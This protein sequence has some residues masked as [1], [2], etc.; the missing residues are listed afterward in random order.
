MVDFEK[1]IFLPLDMPRSP[2]ISKEL[3]EIYEKGIDNKNFVEDEY[4]VS[5]SIIL[6][7]PEGE[8]LPIAKKIPDFVEWTED[9]LFPWSQ[10]SQ[11]VVITTKPNHSMAPH[12]DCA[13][14][15]FA[16]N[17]QH[18]FRHVIRG[19][20]NSLRY[21][22]KD[23]NEFVP[24]T[25][26]PY[27]IS[28]RWP[29]DMKNDYEE[30]KYT[31]CLGAPWEPNLQDPRYKNML[32]KSYEKYKDKYMSYD[33]WKLPNNFKELFNTKRYEVPEDITLNGL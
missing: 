19:N 28:G 7:S 23:S 13:P 32:E 10:R 30:V 8:W 33:G 5:P 25:D 9:F 11:L 29:H 1:L 6:M 31:L 18:K 4:R 2:D 20:T 3:D 16:N 17:I 14:P 21:L 12:I 27:I 26:Q 24:S 15:K 22:K